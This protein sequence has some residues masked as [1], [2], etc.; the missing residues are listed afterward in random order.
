MQILQARHSVMCKLRQELPAQPGKV[1]QSTGPLGFN[2]FWIWLI[3]CCEFWSSSHWTVG[4]RMVSSG[5]PIGVT[6]SDSLSEP[7]RAQVP[8]FI[9]GKQVPEKNTVHERQR[10]ASF[11]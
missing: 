7:E 9:W 5:V 8:Q 2:I 10:L 1:Y 4:I 3:Q 6:L 11:G